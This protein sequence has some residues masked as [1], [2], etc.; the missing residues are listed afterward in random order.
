MTS[1]LAIIVVSC[2]K[3]S[4]LWDIFFQCFFKYWPDCPYKLYLGSNF[5]VYPDERVNNIL[6]GEDIDYSSSLKIMLSEV[7]EDFVLPMVEDFFI[8]KRIDSENFEN[9]FQD[10]LA[11]ESPYLKLIRTYP[12]SYAKNQLR[13]GP[14]E[15]NIKYRVGM[16]ASIWNKNYLSE[17]LIE[18]ESAW[19]IE[20]Y[21]TERSDNYDD[22]FMAIRVS[23]KFPNPF[24]YVHGVVGGRWFWEAVP[25]LIKEGFYKNLSSRR[26]QLIHNYLYTRLYRSTMWLISKLRLNWKRF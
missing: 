22:E 13:I 8:S 11:M 9:Y 26:F 20:R 3:Y 18:G 6:V 14:V 24:D 19:D 5:L 23:S 7:D 16:A 12:L 2:D 25:F 1:K 15:K 10:M 21:G 4:D 17:F